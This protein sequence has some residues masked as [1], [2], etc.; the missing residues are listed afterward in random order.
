MKKDVG[1]LSDETKRPSRQGAARTQFVSP[2]ITFQDPSAAPKT[3]QSTRAPPAD[4]PK[5]LE[6]QLR[7]SPDDR[8]AEVPARVI[9]LQAAVDLLGRGQPRRGQYEDHA[10]DPCCPSRRTIGCMLEVHRSVSTVQIKIKA[11]EVRASRETEL[12]EGLANLQRPEATSVAPVPPV[13]VGGVGRCRRDPRLRAHISLLESGSVDTSREVM[14]QK[15][16]K[17]F[18]AP[19]PRSR[20]RWI[21]LRRQLVSPEDVA[22]PRDP[23]TLMS[24]L[25]NE[26]DSALRNAQTT[27]AVN[28]LHDAHYPPKL[29]Q[30][31]RGVQLE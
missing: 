4:L 11:Q 20:G 15:K 16:A 28:T 9:H 3:R 23:S 12:S 29:N 22:V 17:T 26:A 13:G 25:I 7:G 5:Q 19:S 10:P 24:T 30:V 18:N 1:A 27:R 8:V 14:C 2:P 6:R 21:V 31:G